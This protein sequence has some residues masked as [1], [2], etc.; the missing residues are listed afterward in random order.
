LRA[1]DC[2]YHPAGIWHRVECSA[3][4]ISINVSLIATDYAT[5]ISEGIRHVLWKYEDTR[6]GISIRNMH[7][8][9]AKLSHRL[10][11]LRAS[12]S[13]LRA[14]DFLPN[15]IFLPRKTRY[16]INAHTYNDDNC[17]RLCAKAASIEE[18]K[19]EQAD[20]KKKQKQKKQTEKLQQSNEAAAIHSQSVLSA[21]VLISAV[22]ADS[23]FRVNP[24]AV[25][26]RYEPS[27][28]DPHRLPVMAAASQSEEMEAASSSGEEDA[29]DSSGESSAS[30][31]DSDSTDSHRKVGY[32]LHINFGNEELHSAVRVEVL[33]AEPLVSAMEAVRKAIMKEKMEKFSIKQILQTGRNNDSGASEDLPPAKRRK[34]GTGKSSPPKSAPVGADAAANM[35]TLLFFLAQ[36]G[37]I[38]LQ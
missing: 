18:K 6:E 32:V 10:D 5:L 31:S 26:I 36:Q 19:E 7:D 16:I 13:N 30:G 34:T 37:A 12:L 3:D 24:L 9:R 28:T 2:F 35:R 1:G 21:P 25:L 29:A 27:D 22:D 20:G 23:I 33:I 11:L 15:S 14:E 38:H 4:S 8:A 17:H